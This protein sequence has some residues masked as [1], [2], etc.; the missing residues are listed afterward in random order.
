MAVDYG[1]HAILCK[2]ISFEV[3]EE[4]GDVIRGGIPT[5]KTFM[6]Y[7]YMSDDG[8]RYGAMIEVAEH[9]GMSVVH[10]EDDA[11]ANWLTAKYVR[12]GQDARRVHLR[13]ARPARRGGGGEEGDAPGR[14]CRLAALR[15]AHGRGQRGRR[16]RREPCPGPPLLRRDDRWPTSPSRTRTSGTRRRS[17]RTAST[18]Q[19]RGLLHNNFPTVK[20][21]EDQEALWRAIVDDRLQVV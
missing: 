17:S 9:G 18:Y 19:G 1:L 14:T 6:T 4:I 7:G 8:Q 21:E 12:D 3:L 13:D 11:I 20:F 10:A 16:A 2:D 15:P 5:I